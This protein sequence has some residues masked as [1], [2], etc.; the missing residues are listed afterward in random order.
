MTVLYKHLPA[1]E[2]SLQKKKKKKKKKSS[3]TKNFTKPVLRL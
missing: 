2:E 3:V 1:K